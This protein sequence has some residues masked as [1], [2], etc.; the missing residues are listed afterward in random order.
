M[1]P[2]LQKFKGKFLEETTELLDKM[3]KDLLE[4]E[5]NPSDQEL[6]ESAFR[7]MHTIKGIS[8]MYG[9][10]FICEFT[11]NLENI[12]QAL[13]DK[14]LAFSKDIFD[15]SFASI[16]HIRKLLLDEKLADLN[17]QKNH[18]ELL[19]KTEELLNRQ[20]IVP[21][22]PPSPEVITEV[23]ENQ[24]STWHILFRTSEQLYFR[25]VN[26][27]NIFYDLSKL[28]N[29]EINHLDY[30]S[31]EDTDMWS[32]LLYTDKSRNDIVDILLFIED[33]CT[34]TRLAQKN[35][36]EEDLSLTNSEEPSIL[37]FI[38]STEP[39]SK[40]KNCPEQEQAPNISIHQ[41]KINPR[42]SVDSEKLD[43]L[44]FLVSELI[45]LN[46]Q[47]IVSTSDKAYDKIRPL[48][49]RL[50]DLSKMF[51]NNV[52]EIRLVP[53]SESILRFK[54][55]IRDLSRQ[56]HKKVELVT[57]NMDAELDKG[58]IDQLNEPLI[59]IIRNCIDHGIEPP[60]V[61]KEKGKPETGTIKI[62]ANNSGSQVEI[63]IEDD[64]AGIDLNKVKQKA[65]EKKIITAADEL[66]KQELMDLIFLPG[67]STA[68]SL[69]E[70]SGRGVGM[71]VVRKKISEL[72]GEIKID[73][74]KGKGTS[75]MLKLQQSIAILDTL[76]FKV[77]ETFFT[78]AI[79]DIEECRLV[80]REEINQ[81]SNRGTIP[82]KDQMV[83]FINLRK[84][85]RLEGSYGGIIKVILLKTEEKQIALLTDTIV[86][87]HQSVLKPLGK[88]F[89]NQKCITSASQLGDGRLAFML[90]AS[91]LYQEI[92]N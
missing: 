19:K 50:D 82:Y 67:F 36:F 37:N 15:I 16:D 28:G 43:R 45:T 12:Y 54:R 47:F 70:V 30:L 52:F 58:T 86:G 33:D 49:E 25:G 57:E 3:E 92:E 84:F 34:I 81:Y 26:L 87:A 24:P 11:H 71:D 29:F 73:S 77:E 31:D 48:T 46:S 21:P 4:V 74:E 90:D 62:S 22:A 35:I 5:E 63:C 61:R 65:L 38:E 2:I 68:Q 14:T 91:E 72:R 41:K 76:L 69:S 9:F 88:H 56:L 27:V 60:E 8:G 23:K 75:F 17:N 13:R 6:I 59:H 80:P 1:D 32:I 78:V 85:F 44:M 66:T 51:R 18:Q 64:G 40:L 42:L 7:A 20:E 10:G 39:C 79:S 55:L 83:P 53:L 89:K